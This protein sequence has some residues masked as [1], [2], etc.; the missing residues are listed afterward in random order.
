MKPIEE[1][2]TNQDFV[3]AILELPNNTHSK[4]AL[5][6]MAKP[7]LEQT[8]LLLLDEL[9]KENDTTTVED[10]NGTVEPVSEDVEQAVEGEAVESKGNEDKAVEKPS[11]L[12]LKVRDRVQE[13]AITLD[14][15]KKHSYFPK[16][17][18]K[19]IVVENLGFGDVYVDVVDVNHGD[20]S[21]RIIKG[22]SA[23][24]GGDIHITMI[25]SSTPKVRITEV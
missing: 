22:Q 9:E 14:I 11:D 24:F 3:E 20:K 15:H 17:S 6:K 25:S 5:G 10:V 4:T 13:T 8:Y 19:N 16:D 2:K 7:K 1:L 18:S 21:K 23:E 12:F